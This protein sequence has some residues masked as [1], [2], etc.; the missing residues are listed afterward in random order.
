MPL[1]VS[2]PLARVVE[3]FK[4]VSANND[5]ATLEPLPE[6]PCEVQIKEELTDDSVLRSELDDDDGQCLTPSSHENRINELKNERDDVI[7][8]DEDIEKIDKKDE[9]RTSILEQVLCG[10]LTINDCKELT[11]KSKPTSRWWCS[12]CNTYY[13]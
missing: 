9:K 3:A 1:P 10:N 4:T 2:K 5:V 8:L 6:L 7:I 11:P 12:P 13:R